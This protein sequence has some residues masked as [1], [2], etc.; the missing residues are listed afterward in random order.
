M[1]DTVPFSTPADLVWWGILISVLAV[2]AF[3]ISYRSVPGDMEPVHYPSTPGQDYEALMC[4]LADPTADFPERTHVL[5]GRAAVQVVI[6]RGVP[7][8]G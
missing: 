3:I 1:S 2:F 8:R 4:V 7:S 5:A 6:R